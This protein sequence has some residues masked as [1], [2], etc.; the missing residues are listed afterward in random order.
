MIRASPAI[1]R[2]H[3]GYVCGYNRLPPSARRGGTVWSRAAPNA[4]HQ[5]SGVDGDSGRPLLRKKGLPP[6]QEPAAEFGAISCRDGLM[7][8]PPKPQLREE[9]FPTHSLPC[10]LCL[11]VLGLSSGRRGA[12]TKLRPSLVS[13][14]ALCSPSSNLYN[15]LSVLVLLARNTMDFRL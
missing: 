10:P 14:R 6:L 9:W 8:F 7:V 1:Q 5:F 15:I 11:A 3:A 12:P 4:H 13:V 2:S